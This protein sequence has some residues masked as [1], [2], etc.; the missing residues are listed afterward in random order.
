MSVGARSANDIPQHELPWQPLTIDAVIA[1]LRD[2]AFP[3][4]VAGGYAIELA[5][6]EP[7]RPHDDV[8]VLLLRRDHLAARSLLAEWDCWVADPPGTLRPW[9]LGETL[10][11]T[12]HDVWCR[13]TPDAPWRFQLMLD[14]SDEDGTHWRS[15][16]DPLIT[17]PVAGIGSRTGAGVP[18]LRPEIQLFYKARVHRPKDE[19]DFVAALPLLS[20]AE[21]EWLRDAI[22]LTSGQEHTW[23]SDLGPD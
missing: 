18:F 22:V 17:R 12:V 23:L 5:V 4:W 15:R 8:D 11:D 9:P 10:P 7:V 16:R 1:L 13:E 2:V 19:V 6:G 14:E 21:R 20:A 3:W